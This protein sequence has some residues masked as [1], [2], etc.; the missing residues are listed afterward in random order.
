MWTSR[1]TDFR[2]NKDFRSSENNFRGHDI[3]QGL[4]WEPPSLSPHF[5]LLYYTACICN[6]KDTFVHVR[7][8]FFHH[9]SE[10]NHLS[11]RKCHMPMGETF[12]NFSAT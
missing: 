4:D 7:M 2:W 12:I 8:F 6:S 11:T 1:K 3:S 9:Q 5:L 10:S